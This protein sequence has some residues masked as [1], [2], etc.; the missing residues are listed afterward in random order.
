MD[1]EDAA[2]MRNDSSIPIDCSLSSDGSMPKNHP[3][4][5]GFS[6]RKFLRTALFGAGASTYLWACVGKRGRWRVL[7]DEE[8]LLVDAVTE[9]IVPRDQDPGAR[10]AGVLNFIDKQ[11]TGHYRRYQADYHAGLI[12]VDESSQT[13][14][15]RP[16]LGLKWEEQTRVLKVL[17]SGKAPGKTWKSRSSAEFFEMVRDHTM[18]G[19][20]GSPRHGGNRGYV[21]YRMLGLDYPPI[22]GQ[23][24]YKQA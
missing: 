24:R 6:R 23:N 8:A 3:I 20:Y 7:S 18:Q 11:L 15:G 2:P 1:G 21:S 13:L 22:V 14:F 16:F 4:P 10:D 12:G 17:E 9:Q 19:F 5:N